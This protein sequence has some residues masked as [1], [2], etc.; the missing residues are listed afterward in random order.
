MIF[1][2][3]IVFLLLMGVSSP[4]ST[5][6][7]QRIGDAGTVDWSNF[8]ITSRGRASEN[9]SLPLEVRRESALHAAE[10]DALVR[11]MDLMNQ[12][13]LD[14]ESLVGDVVTANDSVHLALMDTVSRYLRTVDRVY[15]SDG[16]TELD[17]EL[18]LLGPVM[19]LLLPIMDGEQLLGGA[20]HATVF[21]GVVIDARGLELNPCLVPR[22]LNEDGVEVYGRSFVA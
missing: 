5:P 2:L 12:I 22:L 19:G 11:M 16:S 20:P 6:L 18:P 15:L 7:I 17:V 4:E 3:I 13:F 14:A 1:R 9:P 8:M 21:T 10:R